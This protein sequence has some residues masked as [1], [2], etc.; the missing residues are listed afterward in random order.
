MYCKKCGFELQAHNTKC[1]FCNHP[2]EIEIVPVVNKEEVKKVEE[3]EILIQEE[4]KP[5]VEEKIV[6]DVKKQEYVH[7]SQPKMTNL[8]RT[9]LGYLNLKTQFWHHALIASIGYL[10]MYGFIMIIANLMIASYKSNGIDFSCIADDN[11]SA[12]LPGVYDAY[13]KVNVVSQVVAELL[14]VI[15]VALIFMKYLKPLFAEFKQGKTWKWVG[16]GFGLMYGLTIVYSIILTALDLTSSSTNQDSVN[17]IIF[18]NPLLGFLFVV[19]AAPL[20]EEIIFR[21]GIFRIFTNKG[22]KLEIAGVVIT[23]LLF[24][25]VHMTATVEA[26]FADINNPDWELL[27]SDLLSVPSY[28]I[29]AFCLTFAYYK[30]KNL[31]TPMLMHMAWNFMAF[32]SIIGTAG[33]APETGS[34]ISNI[35]NLITETLTRLF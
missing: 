31:I 28:L 18:E 21:L 16:I 22:K 15:A 6:E 10:A 14:V 26:V 2:V 19:V 32:I 33:I 9:S 20:F 34:I 25:F 11:I 3:E 8:K 13:M 30:S 1:P 7:Y 29:C 27:K 17:K 12:C 5:Q 35:F 24:A 4:V 23:T